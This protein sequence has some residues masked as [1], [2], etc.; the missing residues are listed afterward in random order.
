MRLALF[1]SMGPLGLTSDRLQVTAAPPSALRPSRRSGLRLAALLALVGAVTLGNGARAESPGPVCVY[2]WW[3]EVAATPFAIDGAPVEPWILLPLQWSGPGGATSAELSPPDLTV[4][5][6]DADGDEVP[7]E[8]SL[9]PVETRP[10]GVGL[11]AAPRWRPNA[12][13]VAG[14]VYSVH[15]VVRDPDGDPAYDGCYYQGVDRTLTVSVATPPVEP[16]PVPAIR[17]RTRDLFL[18]LFYE[19]CEALPYGLA[20]PDHPEVCC[21]GEARSMHV[22]VDFSSALPN[23]GGYLAVELTATAPGH[24]PVTHTIYPAHD[25]EAELLF[26]PFAPL[27]AVDSMCVTAVLYDLFTDTAVANE[28]V[29]ADPADH[30]LDPAERVCEPALCAANA[31][32]EPGPGADVASGGVDDVTTGAEPD[33][34]DT[35]PGDAMPT[36]VY[37]GPPEAEGCGGGPGSSALF[38]LALA[39]LAIARRRRSA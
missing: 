5:V 8:V 6:T 16:A 37:S 18:P 1:T 20:C 21:A 39:A 13:L 10:A 32:V 11:N 12:P 35:N 17:V 36:D 29:C 22:D 24:E 3:T 19:P 25:S 9:R 15:V 34:V 2:G 26:A 4:T 28:V 23:V 27:P 7:G 31:P 33:V 14:G 38:A 30:Q